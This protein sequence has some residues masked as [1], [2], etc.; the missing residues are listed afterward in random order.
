MLKN[1]EHSFYHKEAFSFLIQIVFLETFNKN[2]DNFE[3]IF[4][5]YWNDFIGH[6]IWIA[7]HRWISSF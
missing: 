7:L 2:A 5:L 3:G 4:S 1:Y 6:E